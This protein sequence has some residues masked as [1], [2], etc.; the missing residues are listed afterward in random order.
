MTLTAKSLSVSAGLLPED[1][2]I[3]TVE[4]EM[5][6][7]SKFFPMSMATSFTIRCFLYPLTLIRT[8]LQ[9]Q[10]GNET[11][12]GTWDAGRKIYKT[13]GFK[14]LYRG[15]FVSV[16]QVVSGLCYVSTYEMVRHL[17]E[18][19][20]G[21]KNNKTKAFVGGGAASIVGQTIIVPFDIISQHL[22]LMGQVSN[23][24]TANELKASVNPFNIELEGRSKAAIAADITRNVYRRD[25][26]KGFYRGYTAAVCTYGTSSA[27][28]W[29]FYHFFQEIY[30]TVIP[31]IVPYTLTQCGAALSAGCASCILTN[32]LDLVRTRVQVQ[33]KPIPETMRKLWK[34][35][36][37][38][39]FTKG[40][41]AR[42]TSSIIYSVAIIFGYETVKKWSVH[43]EYKPKL[44]W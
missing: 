38:R 26:L 15:F 24:K 6:D 34:N 17:L 19:N 21:I 44:K 37:M 41:T 33:R 8:R 4:W 25:G 39:I 27:F 28:W 18:N 1:T 12:N 42:M 32:P 23:T 2:F 40:L 5:L 9:V 36:K 29:T 7:K 10:R 3:K 16:P 43:E 20:L 35:E 13:E 31:S 11:Y 14:G 22:M 30:D